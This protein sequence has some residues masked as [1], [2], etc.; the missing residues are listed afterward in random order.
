MPRV[1]ARTL[2]RQHRYTSETL[3]EGVYRLTERA[4]ATFASSGLSIHYL[5]PAEHATGRPWSTP[6]T[7]DDAFDRPTAV[8]GSVN[9]WDYV[10]KLS[11]TEFDEPY[12]YTYG[13][14]GNFAQQT[15]NYDDQTHRLTDSTTTTQSGA[16]IADKTSYAY[17]PSGNGEHLLGAEAARV[18]RATGPRV[19]DFLIHLQRDG[20]RN[21]QDDRGGEYGP[22]LHGGMGSQAQV[23]RRAPEAEGGR[24]RE[25]GTRPQAGACPSWGR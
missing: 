5:E 20:A 25:R 23:D 3:F 17:Q 12:Q 14:S 15:L 8:G 2:T 4:S 16:A 24:S 6:R 10:D 18:L 13:T 21:R 7:C 11:Y 9:S 19:G 1:V 22:R